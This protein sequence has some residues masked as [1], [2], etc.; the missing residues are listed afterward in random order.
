MRDEAPV[1]GPVVGPEGPGVRTPRF[2]VGRGPATG[3]PWLNSSR[4]LRPGRGASWSPVRCG[5]SEKYGRSAR[6]GVGASPVGPS[7]P[8][9]A[10]PLPPTTEV[11]VGALRGANQ[12]LPLFS[13]AGL[14][15]AGSAGAEPA[16]A[17]APGSASDAPDAPPGA[18][19]PGRGMLPVRSA[20]AVSASLM[21]VR[22]TTGGMGR[23]PGMLIRMRVVSVVSVLGSSD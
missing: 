4:A 13:L 8:P 15:A 16:L 17:S 18:G 14:S 5:P 9:A 2:G 19:E 7:A 21:G 3:P 1:T 12:S 11:F 10:L 6:G 20:S 23:E 22:M